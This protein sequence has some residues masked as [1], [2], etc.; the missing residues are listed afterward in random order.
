[1][2]YQIH[3]LWTSFAGISFGADTWLVASLPAWYLGSLAV[4]S[5]QGQT[6][7]VLGVKAGAYAYL[8]G[9][10]TLKTVFARK[11]PIDDLAGGEP[12]PGRTDDPWSWGHFHPPYLAERPQEPTAFPSSHFAIYFAVARVFHEVYDTP[13]IPYGL[14]LA[15]LGSQIRN[16]AHWVSDMTAGTLLGLGIGHTVVQNF[17]GAAPRKAGKVAWSLQPWTDLQGQARLALTM[18]W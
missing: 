12:Q 8:V 7:A 3:G 5:S 10:V 9:H 1:M 14:A 18:A 16:H 13:W 4:D 15:G 17:R 6:A 11:R 2:T